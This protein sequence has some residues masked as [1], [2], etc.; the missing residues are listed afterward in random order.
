MLGTAL[1]NA[2]TGKVIYTP[3]DNIDAINRLLKNY[4]QYINEE[5]DVP[6]LIK[7]AVQYYQFESIHPFYDGNGRIGRIINIWA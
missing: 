2:S 6:H 4:E 7:M 3:P 5:D 1:R